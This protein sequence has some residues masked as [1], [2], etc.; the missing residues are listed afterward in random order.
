MLYCIR[1]AL[2]PFLALY[3]NVKEAPSLGS[4]VASAALAAVSAAAKAQAPSGEDKSTLDLGS[5]NT[6]QK[7]R[8][9]SQEKVP[10]GPYVW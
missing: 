5:D 8:S 9:M 3:S 4:T 6:I 1:L 7:K 10:M 2:N